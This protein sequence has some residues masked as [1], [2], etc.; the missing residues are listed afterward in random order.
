[1]NGPVLDKTLAVNDSF[2]DDDGEG[3][4]FN[5]LESIDAELGRFVEMRLDEDLRLVGVSL[6]SV[7]AWMSSSSFCSDKRCSIAV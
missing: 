2:T 1:M 4:L 5:V 6:A 3:Y 7:S